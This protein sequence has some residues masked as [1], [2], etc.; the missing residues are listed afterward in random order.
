VANLDAEPLQ[1]RHCSHMGRC[2]LVSRCSAYN[3]PA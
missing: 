1:D 3:S 2:L